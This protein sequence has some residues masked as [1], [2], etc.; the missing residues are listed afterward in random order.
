MTSPQ[1]GALD[2]GAVPELPARLR[3]I[4]TI[5][6]VLSLALTSIDVSVVSTAM[7]K[8]VDDLGG[9]S[10][11]AWVGVSYGVA[12]AVIVPIAGK[13]GD[14][15]GRKPFLLVGLVG[16]MI[17]SWLCGAA[18]SMTELVILRG[19]QGLFAGIQ[20]AS[21]FTVVADIFTAERRTQMQGILFSV[22]GLS[23]VIG[24]PLGG[25]ITDQWG[26]RWVFY[27]N[28]PIL[29]LAIAAILVAVPLV[30]ATAKWRDI[31]YLGALTLI[32]GLVPIL[33]G[34]ALAGDGHA[35]GSPEV[36]VPIVAGV[37]VLV[38]FFLVERRAA[39]PIVPFGLLRTNQFAVMAMVAFFS[40]FAMMGTV[41]YVPLLYQGVQ[42][43]SA[44]FS[45]SL[46][47]PLTLAL[48]I[49]PPFAGKA[50]TM[51]AR[52][53][54]LAV[55][56][57]ALMV[58][59]LLMLSRVGA[60]SGSG[61]TIVAMILIGVGIGITFPMATS[62]VQSAAPPELMGVATSQVQFWRMMAGPVGV[63]TLGA[64]L[65]GALGSVMGSTAA[66]P[67]ADLA[68]ALHRVFLVAAIVV[69]L[70]LVASLFLKEVPLRAMPS[71]GR[72]K[73]KEP[74]QPSKA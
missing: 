71:M 27:I 7:P 15:F 34:L 23:M 72:R 8:I 55:I 12:S 50:L 10:L 40:A 42:G 48:A 65:S 33:I 14:M 67:T 37:V 30:R 36:I 25:L 11:Y 38:L 44:A 6:V 41:F 51:I 70:G 39:H 17:T 64:V 20:M 46:V 19:A 4:A 9:L 13:L 66:V 73:G 56:A 21:I 18:S 62:V 1:A 2:S 68:D 45:G 26:W 63:A 28:V 22:A 35:W 5:G 53:R 29:V 74:A 31:D 59:G 58:A 32:A 61:M 57:F 3:L 49:V 69:A 60:D 43:V 24:P 16:F 54:I 47:I 52:Y